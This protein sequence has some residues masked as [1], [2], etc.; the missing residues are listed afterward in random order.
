MIILRVKCKSADEF[1]NHYQAQEPAG[2]IFCPTTTELQ[3]GTPVVAEIICK[4]LPNRVM[5]RG[6][7]TKWAPAVPRLRVRAGAMVRFDKE[8]AAKRDFMLEALAGKR[9]RVAR[10][11]HPRLPLAMPARIL[12]PPDERGAAVELKEISVVGALLFAAVQPPLD[13]DVVVQIS[14]PGSAAPM[15]LAGR[16]LYHAGKN[17]TG[18]RFIF[19]DAGGARR[20]RE[21]VR[22]FK[23]A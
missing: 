5:V 21:L 13:T 8:E 16:V 9:R 11:R 23:A 3:P 12:M 18:V 20:L 22:R 17:L 6:K 1:R 19:R 2:G 7:V 15:E 10:R 4:A 14:P